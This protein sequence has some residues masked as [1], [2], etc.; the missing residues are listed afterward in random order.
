MKLNLNLEKYK[1][2]SRPNFM[3]K[4][5]KIWNYIW[6][7]ITYK[8]DSYG[9]ETYLNKKFSKSSLT[10][11]LLLILIIYIIFYG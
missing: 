11:F 9:D 8:T 1:Q 6:F 10:L 7:E 2:N 4:F 3:K 5:I